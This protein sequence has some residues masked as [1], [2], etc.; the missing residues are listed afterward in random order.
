[1]LRF[2][3]V[4]LV[5]GTLSTPC[6]SEEL[7]EEEVE[8]LANDSEDFYLAIGGFYR[9]TLPTIEHEIIYQKKAV[10]HYG[11][12]IGIDLWELV[13][14]YGGYSFD[15]AWLN[16]GVNGLSTTIEGK[17]KYFSVPI[18][19]LNKYEK[20]GQFQLYL[21]PGITHLR[22]TYTPDKD[23]EVE[24]FTVDQYGHHFAVGFRGVFLNHFMLSG[25]YGTSR[26]G[27]PKDL[28]NIKPCETNTDIRIKLSRRF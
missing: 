22:H 25:S 18:Y 4:L 7:T 20:K 15:E 14:F 28:D 5:L 13:G 17:T 12:E 9:Q 2:L 26:Y 19:M 10:S 11:M 24:A 1:M 16:D 8:K 6:R 23:V 3:A 27:N 21:E